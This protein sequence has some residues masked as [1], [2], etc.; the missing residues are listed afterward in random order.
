MVIDT[1]SGIVV[2]TRDQLKR[3][4]REQL[5]GDSLV[6]EL[7]SERRRQGSDENADTA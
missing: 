3:L 7:V 5:T 1:T 6:A 2:V 4:V